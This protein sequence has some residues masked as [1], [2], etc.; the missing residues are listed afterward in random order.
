MQETLRKAAEQVFE[1]EIN[2]LKE[3]AENLDTCFETIVEKVCRC[4]G[5][6]IL[7]GMGKSGH[8]AKKIAATL[9][10]LGT[11]SFYLHPA[12]AR[13]GDLG[14]V[15]AKDIVI[16]I[17]NSGETEELIAI[18][19]N[20][21][22]IGSPIIGIA[23]SATSNLLQNSDIAYV[24][25]KFEEAC[26]LKLAPTSSTTA[27]LVLGDAIAVCASMQKGFTKENFALFHPSGALGKRLLIHVKDIMIS[28][29]ENAVISENSRLKDAIIELAQKG[30][31]VVN[32]IQKDGA[33]TGVFT[34]GDLRRLFAETNF[35]SLDDI[36]LQSVISTHPITIERNKLAVDA[37][38]IMQKRNISALPVVDNGKLCGTVL[39]RDTI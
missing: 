36:E 1:I 26:Y 30:L 28:G 9:S 39:L 4:Q 2:A 21:K 15:T 17:S 25:P 13:H 37:L 29:I 10:S 32:I 35:Q 8:I 20:L 7:T 22:R 16:A 14:M 18:L 38:K 3:T 12:E 31:G 11:P 19:P 33:L 6:V 24:L 27:A 34:D 5:N 23:S